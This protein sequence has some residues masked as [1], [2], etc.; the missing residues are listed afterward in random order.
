MTGKLLISRR[1]KI[2]RQ[3]IFGVTV[4]WFAVANY[5]HK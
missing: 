1:S 5:T 3:A 2:E 4:H